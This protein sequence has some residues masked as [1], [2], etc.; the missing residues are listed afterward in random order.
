MKSIFAALFVALFVSTVFAQEAGLEIGGIAPPSAQEVILK[1]LD[2]VLQDYRELARQELSSDAH[3]AFSLPFDQ[4]NLY[5][6]AFGERTTVELSVVGPAT[7]TVSFQDGDYQIEGSP[8]TVEMRAF[9]QKNEELQARHFAQLKAGIDEAAA[10][11][12][13][14]RLEEL[15]RQVEPALQAFL[16]E[17]R[18]AI[19]ELGPTPAGYYALQF[20]DFNKELDFIES[21]LQA[22]QEAIPESPVTL[23]LEQQLAKAKAIV[24]GGVPPAI[25]AVDRDGRP[26]SL[27]DF[28]GRVL[29]IDFWASWCRACRIENP[30]FVELYQDYHERG[31]DILSISQDDSPDAWQQAIAKDGTGLWPQVLDADKQISE[32]YSVSSLPQNVLLGPD[33]RI[34]AK[35]LGEEDLRKWLQKVVD[36]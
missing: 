32:R 26:V 31:F 5:Q 3:F 19:V 4:P 9:R 24:V 23:V 34:V 22:F 17:F 8:S 25:E 2:P 13:E 28:Q 11:G 30:K 7:I 6:L 15:T 10:A 14:T 12:D 33:G 16:V 35:N 29:L 36:E 18:Q 27:A 1:S 20:S 21:R